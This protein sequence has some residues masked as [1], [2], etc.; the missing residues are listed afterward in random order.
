MI[1][2]YL[3]ID[4]KKI[5]FMKKSQYEI[6]SKKINNNDEFRTHIIEYTKFLD[7]TASNVQRIWHYLHS[8]TEMPKCKNCDTKVSFRRGGG[9]SIGYNKYCSNTCKI[10][11]INKNRS[12]DEKITRM[13]KIKN[14]CLKK[15]GVHHFSA[16]YEIKNKKILTTLS[17]YGVDNPS[18]S[19][20]I[21]LKKQ[22]TC[23]DRYGVDNP[24]KVIEF[25]SK[26]SLSSKNKV[27]ISP[28]GKVYNVEGYEPIVLNELFSMG[29]TDDDILTSFDIKKEIGIIKYKF[30]GKT[31]IYHPDIYIKS[32]NILI[33]AK[34]EYWYYRFLDNNIAKQNYC[35]TINI[36]LEFWV[37][38]S[39]T[40]NKEI[41]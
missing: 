27:Y 41:K 35:G 40:K 30:N 15:Y 1:I 19:D 37:Y 3:Y 13:Q 16:S 9:K 17:N 34:S 11:F 31:K 6:L 10:T 22:K 23:L 14:T 21:K 8:I 18:K 29:Y 28:T 7:Y 39:V 5:N 36:P 12:D 33:D 4:I 20:I 38:D 26:K 2:L 24:S 32:K 25:H